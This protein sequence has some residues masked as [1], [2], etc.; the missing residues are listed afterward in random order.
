[1][2]TDRCIYTCYIQESID[3]NRVGLDLSLKILKFSELFFKCFCL[4]DQNIPFEPKK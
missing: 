4:I 1:M 2:Y 3:T